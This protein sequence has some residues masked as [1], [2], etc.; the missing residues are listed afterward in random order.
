MTAPTLDLPGLLTSWHLSL[1]ADRKSKQTIDAYT[2]GVTLFLRWC[3]EHG[4]VPALD[5]NLVRIWVADL[6]DGGAQPNTARTRQMALKRFAAWALDE[7]E[8]DSNELALLKPPKLDTKVVDRLSDDEC[9]ALVKA[10]AG[11]AFIDRRDEAIVRLM[12][13]TGLRAGEVMGFTVE[14][15]D[16]VRGVALVQRGKGGKGRTVPFGPQAARAIDRYLRMRRGHRLADTPALWLGGSSQSLGYHGLDRAMKIRAERAGLKGFHLHLLRHTAASRWL[17]AGG[18]EGG[19]M[20]VAGWSS[21]EMLDRYTRS[22]ASD[23]AAVEAR[24]LNLGDL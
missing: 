11:K 24:S 10:C 17:A 8:I 7:G 13:E 20:A 12:L 15:I 1:K 21:R 2:M 19:L 16:L 3:G 14:D 23:R 4:H 5:R 9:A 18:S 22:T 6:L